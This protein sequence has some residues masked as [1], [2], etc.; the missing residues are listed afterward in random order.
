[1]K[2]LFVFL[3]LSLANICYGDD[4]FAQPE[5]NSKYDGGSEWGAKSQSPDQEIIERCKRN[6][7][8][9]K[10]RIEIRELRP[11]GGDDYSYRFKVEGMIL[12][13][14][15]DEAGYYEKRRLVEKFRIPL[16][17]RARKFE[18]S[19]ITE[20]DLKGQIRVY[21]LDGKQDVIDLDDEI[22]QYRRSHI[23]LR[24]TLPF[25]WN[26]QKYPYTR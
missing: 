8:P 24:N 4:E 1:M 17:D 9:K 14:C 20:L 11:S 13:S 21:T 2:L 26:L 10:P 16:D 7:S 5:S 23:R 15:I 3:F 12:G 22:E 18:F 25:P 6:I 19:I